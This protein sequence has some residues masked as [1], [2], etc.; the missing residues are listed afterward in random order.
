[1]LRRRKVEA[2]VLSVNT[3]SSAKAAG[4]AA[5]DHR[6]LTM[7]IASHGRNTGFDRFD[8]YTIPGVQVTVP[9]PGMDFRSPIARLFHARRVARMSSAASSFRGT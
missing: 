6:C 4:V 3:K 5:C 2:T 8:L 9:G 1:M 7:V